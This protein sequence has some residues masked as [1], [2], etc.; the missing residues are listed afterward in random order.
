MKL[1]LTRGLRAAAVAALVALA[2]L[3]YKQRN[4]GMTRLRNRIGLLRTLFIGS[5]VSLLERLKDK[6]EFLM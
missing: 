6:L 2:Y 4:F 3:T 5:A 1:A